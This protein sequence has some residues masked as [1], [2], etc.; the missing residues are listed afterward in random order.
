MA[1]LNSVFMSGIASMHELFNSLKMCTEEVYRV[2]Q[3]H[4]DL[5]GQIKSLMAP[6]IESTCLNQSSY[7]SCLG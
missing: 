7:E 6:L 5:E 1:L 4:I 2:K 3:P